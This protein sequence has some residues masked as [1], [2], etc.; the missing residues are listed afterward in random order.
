MRATATE[1]PDER[2][3][4]R[5]GGGEPDAMAGALADGSTVLEVED[6]DDEEELLLLVVLVGSM[7]PL[8]AAH[9]GSDDST[10]RL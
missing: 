10:L 1:A 2:V 4:V 6:D 9:N 5:D 3:R 8:A 7:R